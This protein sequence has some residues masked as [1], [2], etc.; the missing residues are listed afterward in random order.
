MTA[1]A[2]GFVFGLGSSLHCAAMC[3]PLA[4]GIGGHSRVLLGYHTARTASYA[5]AGFGLG[6]MGAHGLGDLRASAPWIGVFL[7]IGLVLTLG[8]GWHLLSSLAR[9][10]SERGRRVTSTPSTPTSSQRASL[11]SRLIGG[12]LASAR[13]WPHSGRV[14]LLGALTPLLPCGV[15]WVVYGTAVISGDAVAG[16]RTTLGF[17]CGSAP[18]LLLAHLHTHW[19]RRHLPPA[20]ARWL[21]RIAVW[22]AAALL[23]W[24]SALALS[25]GSCCE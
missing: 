4:I 6:A 19:L 15:S 23:L 14:A 5:L 10:I 17:A 13:R 9:L 7:A 1:I 22:S 3:G 24:R 12:A 2:E 18:L 20:R 25:G 11:A 21:V 16:M 8:G